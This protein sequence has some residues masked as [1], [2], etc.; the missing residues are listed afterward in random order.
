MF[1]ALFVH[2]KGAQN[3]RNQLLNVFVSCTQQNY[4]KFRN[5]LYRCVCVLQT[6]LGTENYTMLNTKI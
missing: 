5:V 3:C 1:R 6:E 2:Q 4:R